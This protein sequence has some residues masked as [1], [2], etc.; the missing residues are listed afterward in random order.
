MATQPYDVVDGKI[1]AKMQELDEMIL[2]NRYDVQDRFESAIVKQ[3]FGHGKFSKGLINE[4]IREE[5][6]EDDDLLS[7][8]VIQMQSVSKFN[9]HKIWKLD[10]NESQYSGL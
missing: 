8:G 4:P 9:T 2:F 3:D 7:F 6:G 10:E 1:N 5:E